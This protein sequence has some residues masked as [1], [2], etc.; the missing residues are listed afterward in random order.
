VAT[1]KGTA[2]RERVAAAAAAA[3]LSE[4][5]AGDRAEL[6]SEVA[7][8]TELEDLPGRWQAA[9]LAAESGAPAA[10]GCCG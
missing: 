9:V 10:H 7:L 6:D 5:S 3:P 2:L 1:G 8:A 4:L